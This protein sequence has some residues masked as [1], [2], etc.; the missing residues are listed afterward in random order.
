MATGHAALLQFGIQFSANEHY[1]T[2]YEEPEHE[3]DGA[4]E[5]RGN[6]GDA[7]L[8]LNEVG[9]EDAEAPGDEHQ[10]AHEEGDW[11]GNGDFTSADLVLAF[12]LPDLFLLR[13]EPTMARKGM[14]ALFGE[15]L[16]PTVYA[17]AANTQFVLNL[18][19]AFAACLVQPQRFKL[20]VTGVSSVLPFHYCPPRMVLYHRLDFA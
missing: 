11:D 3:D 15:R 18:G 2:R 12:Q 16:L 20:K 10:D 7:D 8:A 6:G 5:G 4:A 13:R 14:F 1:Q 17:A 9:N 19:C